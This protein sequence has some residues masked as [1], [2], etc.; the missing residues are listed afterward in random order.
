MLKVVYMK[1]KTVWI[2]SSTVLRYKN[3]TNEKG[4]RAGA[5]LIHFYYR[6]LLRVFVLCML[7]N[8]NRTEISMSTMWRLY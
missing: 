6:H 2:N 3:P 1:S 7:A 5:R 8:N 4:A